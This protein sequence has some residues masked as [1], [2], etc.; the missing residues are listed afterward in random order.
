MRCEKVAVIEPEFPVSA[1]EYAGVGVYSPVPP[2]SMW[3]MSKA[4]CSRLNV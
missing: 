3:R 1:A 2:L 4:I